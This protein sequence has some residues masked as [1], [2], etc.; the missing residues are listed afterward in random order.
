MVIAIEH[1]TTNQPV[2]LIAFIEKQYP[3]SQ[4]KWRIPLHK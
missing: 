1:I 3:L 4:I 2:K